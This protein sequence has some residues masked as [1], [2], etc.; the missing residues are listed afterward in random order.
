[1]YQGDNV[2]LQNKIAG[3]RYDLNLKQMDGT[4]LKMRRQGVNETQQ[5]LA[6]YFGVKR[7]TINRWEN[8]IL[9]VPKLVEIAIERLEIFYKERNRKQARE[10]KRMEKAKN[11]EP[12]VM[13][14]AEYDE[15]E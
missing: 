11:I 1:M 10:N 15:M 9:E 12:R 7:N 4:E 14:Q 6:N 2:D 3:R 8:G 13:T 5:E